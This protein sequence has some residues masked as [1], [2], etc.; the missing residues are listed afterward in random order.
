MKRAETSIIHSDEVRPLDYLFD[1]PFIR[2][3][4]N[5]PHDIFLLTRE[6]T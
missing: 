2:M 3:L 6:Y 1:P 5:G 4:G